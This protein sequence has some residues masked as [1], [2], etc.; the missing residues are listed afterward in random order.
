LSCLCHVW[1]H[2]GHRG[3][4][5]VVVNDDVAVTRNA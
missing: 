2:S 5:A 1:R 4:L 3:S